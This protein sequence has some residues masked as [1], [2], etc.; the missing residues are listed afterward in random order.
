LE[1]GDVWA[2]LF[3]R[4]LNGAHDSLVDAKAQQDIVTHPSFLSYINRKESIRL[5]SD[6]FSSAEQNKMAKNWNQ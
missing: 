2:H 1:L 5:V 3:K 6:I 4:N